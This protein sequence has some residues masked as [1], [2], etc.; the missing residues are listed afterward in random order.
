MDPHLPFVAAAYGLSAFVVI[1]L[2]VWI[3]HDHRRLSRA[4]AELEARGVRRRSAG[5]TQS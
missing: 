2:V 1:G 3:V 5:E 4:I